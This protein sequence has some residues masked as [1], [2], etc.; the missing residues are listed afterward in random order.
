ME[1]GVIKLT[2][3]ETL[4]KIER[5]K[6]RLDEHLRA[7]IKRVTELTPDQRMTE[8]HALCSSMRRLV[9]ALPDDKKKFALIP[10]PLP[11]ETKLRMAEMRRKFRESK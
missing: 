4:A 11:A 9:L 3:E 1:P 5:I 2:K 10:S 8:Y 7:E 6:K